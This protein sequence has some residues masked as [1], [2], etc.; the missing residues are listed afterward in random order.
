MDHNTRGAH[1]TQLNSSQISRQQLVLFE[2][3]CQTL[4]DRV[5]YQRLNF[6]DAVDLAYEAATWS[7]LADAVGDD[8][9]QATMANAFMKVRQP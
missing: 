8:V 1:A 7:G 6:V 3:R 4:A 5:G 9:V 2:R